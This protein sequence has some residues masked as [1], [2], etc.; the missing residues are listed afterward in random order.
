[1]LANQPSG[2][3][4]ESSL[5]DLP[6][7]EVTLH[8]GDVLY[9]PRGTIH[10]AMAGQDIGSSHLTLSTYQRW[11][12]GDAAMAALST[13][14][15]TSRVQRALPAACT[16]GLPAAYLFCEGC[17]LRD[18]VHDRTSA[19]VQSLKVPS[20]EDLR[21]GIADALRAFADVLDATEKEDGAVITTSTV[22]AMAFDFMTHRLPPHP[23]QLPDQ[24][25]RPV[26]DNDVI[27]P[28][29]PLLRLFRITTAPPP[30]GGA[31][32][33]DNGS[34]KNG[35]VAVMSCL[36]N[37]RETH[38]LGGD[39]RYATDDGTSSE[40]D[41]DGKNDN[42][43][44]DEEGPVAFPRELQGALRQILFGSKL[45]VGDVQLPVH[46]SAEIRVHLAQQLYDIGAIVCTKRKKR[47]GIPADD[48][49][50]KKKRA[51]K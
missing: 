50:S 9:M 36:R 10:Q 20:Q 25:P 46:V 45:R 31:G 28:R 16:A 5:G 11:S 48:D 7:M 23:Q 12:Y 3:L 40:D 44:S 1:M 35:W 29:A 14:L 2:D 21:K 49:I 32:D 19:E 6:S 38:M 18:R 51:N 43:S 15:A 37:D 8:P 42:D 24:G 39:G 27:E 26:S 41:C 13:A 17:D 22:D 34:D 30:V 33:M 47:R 4:P